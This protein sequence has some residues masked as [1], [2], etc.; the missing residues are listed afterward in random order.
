MIF[1]IVYNLLLTVLQ[2]WFVLTVPEDFKLIN[3]IYSSWNRQ[4]IW[5]WAFRQHS[6]N[7]RCRLVPQYPFH[8]EEIVLQICERYSPAEMFDLFYR[9]RIEAVHHLGGTRT[10]QELHLCW[11]QSKVS[12]HNNRD[13]CSLLT[14]SGML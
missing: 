7:Y 14:M 12:C 10:R 3:W 9:S 2:L 5:L 4:N 1:S 8:M 11:K 6:F 13:M